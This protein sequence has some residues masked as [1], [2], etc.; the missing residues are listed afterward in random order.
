MR[1]GAHLVSD[2]ESVAVF[3]KTVKRGI[4]K[5]GPWTRIWVL[6][7]SCMSNQTARNN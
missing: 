4:P 7:G 1:S 3:K 2:I 5:T 6:G